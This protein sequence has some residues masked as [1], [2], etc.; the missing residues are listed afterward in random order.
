MFPV[1]STP[2]RQDD[3]EIEEPVRR[4]SFVGLAST[5]LLSTVL[6]ISAD[7]S[8]PDRSALVSVVAGHIG[9][10]RL[11]PS[12]PP[13]DIA[14]LTAAANQARRRY[15]ACQYS[16]LIRL[17]PPLLMRLNI[18]SMLL[19]GEAKIRAFV[20]CADAHHVAA[21]LLLKLDDQ[22]LAYLAADRSMRAALAS[23]DPVAIGSS[24][25]IVT[26]ALMSGG[27]LAV[28]AATASSHATNLG[29]DVSIH[30]PESLSVYGSLLL[31]GA[32]AAAQHGRRATA[33]EL[34][35]EADGA[36]QRLDVDG[37][38]R[39]T[40]FGRTNVKLHRVNVA[41]TLGDAGTAVEVARGIDPSTITVAER[42]ASLLI[43]ISRAFLQ[44]GR[45]ENAYIAL[46]AAEQAAHEEVAGRPSVHRLVRQ[47]ITS[48]PLTVRRD[49]TEFA[50]RIGAFR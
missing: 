16:E 20:L 18:A 22:G 42:K 9:D 19:D 38:L 50:T 48:A 25:R 26:H 43:D 29:R 45:Y 32:V 5:S 6:D 39:W 15:Q 17:L 27:H 11:E 12:G 21:G 36:A 24:A 1:C 4:R 40:A 31:R 3:Q 7:G 23:Q 46:C 34:L 44:W 37:N 2:Q 35:D 10:A 28:A 49:A 14:T 47:L 8:P 33:H 41:V 30:T 13:S